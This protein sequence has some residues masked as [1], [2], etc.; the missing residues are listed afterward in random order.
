M[1]KVGDKLVLEI[2]GNESAFVTTDYDSRHNPPRPIVFQMNS[3]S[4][5]QQK[6]KY[7]SPPEGSDDDEFEDIID[8]EYPEE[9]MMYKEKPLLSGPKKISSIPSKSDKLLSKS[10]STSQPSSKKKI[11]Q[12]PKKKKSGEMKATVYN[13]DEP[14]STGLTPI[15]TPEPTAAQKRSNLLREA[16]VEK[17]PGSEFVMQDLEQ[18]DNVYDAIVQSIITLRSNP[19]YMFAVETARSAGHN[20]SEYYLQSGLQQIFKIF[21]ID[22][23]ANQIIN[24]YG[25]QIKVY[26]DNIRSLNRNLKTLLQTDSFHPRISTNN[27]ESLDTAVT[28]YQKEMIQNMRIVSSLQKEMMQT[29]NILKNSHLISTMKF[30]YSGELIALVNEAM[31]RIE[32]LRTP[33]GQLVSFRKYDPEKLIRNRP[34]LRTSLA[35]LC[36]CINTQTKM[37]QGHVVVTR[38]TLEQVNN[39]ISEITTNMNDSLQ[40]FDDVMTPGTT[41]GFNAFVPTFPQEPQFSFVE[42]LQ[43][44]IASPVLFQGPDFTIPEIPTTL[45]SGRKRSTPSASSSSSRSS[46]VSMYHVPKRYRL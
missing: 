19:F 41:T 9:S 21:T 2:S 24:G 23:K 3:E 11:P 15:M 5:S 33:D 25:K 20:R 31:N 13:L 14:A 43:P 22:G 6:D 45:S 1:R 7:R 17:M 44:A 38:A 39:T 36:G 28:E 26:S 40:G 34:S 42:S 8:T 4:E 32:N 27:L 29:I 18:V 37:E 46:T 30:F 35:R 12:N 10:P 16:L